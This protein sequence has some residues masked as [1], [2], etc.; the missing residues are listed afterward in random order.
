MTDGP[1][2]D[3]D[4]S[5]DCS[6][7]I[8]VPALCT[9]GWRSTRNKSRRKGASLAGDIVSHERALRVS[10]SPSKHV[11]SLPGSDSGWQLPPSWAQLP[12]NFVNFQPA[13]GLI[14]VATCS[15]ALPVSTCSR[16]HPSPRP[17]SSFAPL[18]PRDSQGY[19]LPPLDA[20]QTAKLEMLLAKDKPHRE[21]TT[22]SPAA[23]T[24]SHNNGNSNNNNNSASASASASIAQDDGNDLGNG[25]DPIPEE[26]DDGD[27]DG[28]DDGNGNGNGNAG[29]ATRDSVDV[30]ADTTVDGVDGQARDASKSSNASSGD[31]DPGNPGA[32]TPVPWVERL[33]CGCGELGPGDRQRKGPARG[34]GARAKA[35]K[36]GGGSGGGMMRMCA[37]KAKSRDHHGRWSAVGNDHDADAEVD[38][39]VD[40]DVDADAGA[41]DTRSFVGRI[42]VYADVPMARS[43]RVGH[44]AERSAD[45]TSLSDM[46]RHRRAGGEAVE[47]R[48]AGSSVAKTTAGLVPVDSGEDGEGTMPKATDELSTGED[49]QQPGFAVV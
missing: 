41:E 13:T 28:D 30:N 19:E 23:S 36:V 27:S 16:H 1:V 10:H 4:G 18:L 38:P 21:S 31:D 35:G 14:P 34:R 40:A 8:G 20:W 44:S 6:R 5:L 2:S 25:A 26:T 11:L 33:G 48:G 47:S 37:G 46:Y 7:D 32:A 3:R 22:T 24:D 17:R 9:L 49:Q 15:I 12:G 43:R 29:D 39:D 42:P 45:L